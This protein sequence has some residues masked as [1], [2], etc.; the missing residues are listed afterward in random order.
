MPTRG[1][2]EAVSGI[3]HKQSPCDRIASQVSRRSRLGR[4]VAVNFYRGDKV[5]SYLEVGTEYMTEEKLAKAIATEMRDKGW[6]RYEYIRD[7]NEKS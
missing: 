6:D 5:M 4:V 3:R 2:S 7:T 1:G